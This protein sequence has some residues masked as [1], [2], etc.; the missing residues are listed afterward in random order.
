MVGYLYEMRII[1]SGVNEQAVN[2]VI[3]FNIVKK[4]YKMPYCYAKVQIKK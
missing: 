3:G 4:S 2:T 1:K